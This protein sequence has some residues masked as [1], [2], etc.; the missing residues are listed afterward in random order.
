[1]DG[2]FILELEVGIKNGRNY[3]GFEDQ[4]DTVT[5]SEGYQDMIS[6]RGITQ[7]CYESELQVCPD[8]CRKG[9]NSLHCLGVRL[10]TYIQ[11]SR[12]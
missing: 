12:K 7:N 6:R 9:P 2:N 1:D 11:S 3:L 5:F 10:T 8:C 4:P